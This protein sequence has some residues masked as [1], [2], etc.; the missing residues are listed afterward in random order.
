MKYIF[1]DR[2]IDHR[3]EEFCFA[4]IVKMKKYKKNFLE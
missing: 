3:F 1:N 4:G 2:N